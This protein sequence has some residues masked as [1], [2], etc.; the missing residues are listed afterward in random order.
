VIDLAQR[1]SSKI[2]GQ[3]GHTFNV[4]LRASWR[5]NNRPGFVAVYNC[6]CGASAALRD[7]EIDSDGIAECFGCHEQI[8]L[9]GFLED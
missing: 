4:P 9:V 6:A 1:I 8:R 2:E 3:R 5:Q 7:D